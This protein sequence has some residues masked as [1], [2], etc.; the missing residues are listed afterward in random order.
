[1]SV[2][3]ETKIAALTKEIE[4]LKARL[5]TDHQAKLVKIDA[6][7]EKT[8]VVAD[9]LFTSAEEGH[10]ATQKQLAEVIGLINTKFAALEQA[11]ENGKKPAKK[12]GEKTKLAI[13]GA[14][15]AENGAAPNGEAAVD[16]D[17]ASSSKSGGEETVKKAVA[18]MKKPTKPTSKNYFKTKYAGDASFRAAWTTPE[19]QVAVD[20]DAK[21][22][23]EKKPDMKLKK[24][25]DVIFEIVCKKDAP[26]CAEWTKI[27]EDDYQQL[28]K[29]EPA[30]DQL[31]SEAPSPQ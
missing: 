17:D 4:A 24:A 19:L 21:Y 18:A 3:V 27:L 8:A 20:A 15:G 25:A 26:R 12:V 22:L 28:L 11:L 2:A 10:C 23:A 29:A 7:T 6:C 13:K 1:M 14:E 31:K 5:D 9:K 16:G 30:T